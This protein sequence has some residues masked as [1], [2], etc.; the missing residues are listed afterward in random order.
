MNSREC[1]ICTNMIKEKYRHYKMWRA[2]AIIFMCLT[3][4]F[5]VLFFTNSHLFVKEPTK[6]TTSA[7]KCSTIEQ[8]STLSVIVVGCTVVLIERHILEHQPYSV[9]AKL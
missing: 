5:A 4:F 2:F 9:K 3:V 6:N 1:E 8:E 7:N